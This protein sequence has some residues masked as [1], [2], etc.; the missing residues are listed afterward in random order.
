VHFSENP[1]KL[2][3]PSIHTRFWDPFL[4]ACEETGTGGEPA[5][6]FVLDSPEPLQ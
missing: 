1:E 3:L 5:P 4:Q 6:G 2:G